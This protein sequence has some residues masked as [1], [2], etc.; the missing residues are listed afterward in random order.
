MCN[1]LL[2]EN[3]HLRSPQ[4]VYF[5]SKSYILAV[6]LVL[7]LF[8]S[9]IILSYRNDTLMG[10]LWQPCQH[11]YACMSQHSYNLVSTLCQPCDNLATKWLQYDSPQ[12]LHR[13]TN[14][15]LIH[16]SSSHLPPF[17]KSY[18]KNCQFYLHRN[19]PDSPLRNTLPSQLYHVP[20]RTF[21]PQIIHCVNVY[22][23]T[24]TR[25]QI[26]TY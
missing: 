14:W 22:L 19:D 26:S 9:I 5:S 12:I 1:V 2:G 18:F 4:I 13:G 20:K 17:Q 6:L 24:S 23:T 3:I 21:S 8:V 10:T 11:A 16:I 25:H 7:L 15:P